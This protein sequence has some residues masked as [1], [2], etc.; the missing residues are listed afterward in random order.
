MAIQDYPLL[1]GSTCF[2]E[3]PIYL[4]GMKIQ[5]MGWAQ[6]FLAI[7]VLNL[8]SH[9]L[10]I[11]GF[12]EL[13]SRMGWSYGTNT[14]VAE[15]FALLIESLLLQFVWK[16]SWPLAWG[17]GISANIFSWWAGIELMKFHI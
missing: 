8:A 6:C 13:A 15:A 17:M 5:K 7:F 1:F 14:L 9:P 16:I 10:V 3:A 12:P 2:L 11:F 4:L